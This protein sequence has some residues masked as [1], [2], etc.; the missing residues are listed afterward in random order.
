[1]GTVLSKCLQHKK[2]SIIFSMM[3]SQKQILEIRKYPEPILRKKSVQV[4]EITPKEIKLFEDMLLTM[5]TSKSEIEKGFRMQF[6]TFI[7]QRK[8][9]YQDQYRIIYNACRR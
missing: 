9:A 4:L 7:Q 5:Y 6:D 1:M 3:E 8:S 2:L